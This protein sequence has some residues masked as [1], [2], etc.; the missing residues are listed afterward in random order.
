MAKPKT[1]RGPTDGE[2]PVLRER[3]QCAHCATDR[4]VE[5][6]SQPSTFPCPRC[7]AIGT[8]FCHQCGDR[9]ASTTTDDDGRLLCPICRVAALKAV[10]SMASD[11][12][13]ECGVP[14]HSHIAECR[15]LVWKIEERVMQ[16]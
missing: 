13:V 3:R 14:V 12:C 7:G 2:P 6:L 8:R 16:L 15:E 1:L 11:L 4:P 9:S 10:A 5:Q